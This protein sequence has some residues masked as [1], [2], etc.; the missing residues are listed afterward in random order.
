MYSDVDTII[1]ADGDFPRSPEL[2]TMLRSAACIICCDGAADKLL[3][4]GR[5]PDLVIG[6]LDSLSAEAKVRCAGRLV[7]VTEQETND[8]AKSFRYCREH[9]I[10]PQALLGASGG[11]EDHFLGNLGQFA[12]FSTLF[13]DLKFYTDRGYFVAVSGTRNFT[14]LHPGSQI[15]FFT[16]DPAQQLA[17]DGVK[18][19]LPPTLPSWYSGTLNE[20]TGS[21]L[22]V[23][24]KGNIPLLLFFCT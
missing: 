9:A 7:K 12:E 5:V 6:D 19:P 13:P 20:L 18:Y 15:S 17:A 10:V 1:L 14:G 22:T 23:T 21:E 11:R 4:F 16:F 2:L 24:N 8:L 3:H